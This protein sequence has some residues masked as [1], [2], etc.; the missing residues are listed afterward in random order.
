LEALVVDWKLAIDEER[1][2]LMRI[3]ALLFSLADLAESAS[4]RCRPVR[5][6][7]LWLLRPAETF[8]RGFVMGEQDAPPVSM[9]IG[10]AGDSRAD[11]MRLADNFRDLACELK[12]QARLAFAI[13]D[14]AGRAGLPRFGAYRTLD[15]DDFLN[16]LRLAVATIACPEQFQEKWKPVFRPELRKNKALVARATGQPDTS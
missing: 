2:A 7:V 12:C 8:A 14:G 9:P 4:R 15:A 11:A 3:V 6:F 5:S 16:S 10:P 1:A 13:Q